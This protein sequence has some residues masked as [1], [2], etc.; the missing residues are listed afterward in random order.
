MRPRHII[1]QVRSGDPVFSH[2]CEIAFLRVDKRFMDIVR[3]RQV[4]LV[5]IKKKDRLVVS[6]F[7]S[8]THCQFLLWTLQLANAR[9]KD[10][11]LLRDVLATGLVEMSTQFKVVDSMVAVVTENVMVVSEKGIYFIAT[12]DD[13]ILV[14][15]S[16]ITNS[17]LNQWSES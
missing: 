4:L 1:I 2:N 8:D 15:S 9:S 12:I 10:G 5:D 16:L 7:Y 13:E 17:M 11:S 14:H 6:V 3:N